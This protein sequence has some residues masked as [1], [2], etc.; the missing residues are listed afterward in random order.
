MQF[1]EA[2]RTQAGSYGKRLGRLWRR[3]RGSNDK[4][5]ARLYKLVEA[6]PQET[7]TVEELRGMVEEAHRQVWGE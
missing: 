4:V 3:L 2:D 6:Q 5:M 1:K 7:V